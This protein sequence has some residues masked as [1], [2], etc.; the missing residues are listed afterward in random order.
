MSVH[1]NL[2]RVI[3]TTCLFL[4]LLVSVL[5]V[6]VGYNVLVAFN[7]VPPN[8][9]SVGSETQVSANG[10]PRQQVSVI[11]LSSQQRSASSPSDSFQHL[12]DAHVPKHL[13]V[14]WDGSNSNLKSGK[15]GNRD[16]SSS[17]PQNNA[18]SDYRLTAIK[19]QEIFSRNVKDRLL[20]DA[21]SNKE[22]GS[23][24][25]AAGTVLVSQVA[26]IGSGLKKITITTDFDARLVEIRIGNDTI[27]YWPWINIT[28]T[29]TQ[30]GSYWEYSYVFNATSLAEG[31]WSVQARALDASST[32]FYSNLRWFL[33]NDNV[34]MFTLSNPVIIQDSDHVP[35][36]ILSVSYDPLT[37]Y[38]GFNL[39]V[40]VNVIDVGKGVQQV[41]VSYRTTSSV[42]ESP[43][44]N[45]TAYY[46]S[47][48]GLYV[49]FLPS[50]VAGTTVHIKAYAKDASTL[51]NWAVS[52]EITVLIQSP[53][54]NGNQEIP[55]ALIDSLLENASVQYIYFEE[56]LTFWI[57]WG[58]IQGGRIYYLETTN[59]SI[60]LLIGTLENGTFIPDYSQS[61]Q[62]ATLSVTYRGAGNYSFVILANDLNKIVLINVTLNKDGFSPLTYYLL[63]VVVPRP[64]IV[65]V[66]SQSPEFRLGE[67]ATII[68]GWR[69]ALNQS[70]IYHNVSV[71]IYL[72]GTLLNNSQD[73]G[74]LL[75]LL[76]Q[77][78]PLPFQ[79][80][81][82]TLSL[83]PAKFEW[84]RGTYNLTIVLIKNGYEMTVQEFLLEIKGFEITLVVNYPDEV[85]A[86]SDITITVRLQLASSN[87]SSTGMS[88]LL[89]TD[90]STTSSVSSMAFQTLAGVNV[91][92]AVTLVYL[93]GTN[94][95]WVSWD[96][97][98]VL[99][100]VSFTI[101]G[102]LTRGLFAISQIAVSTPG[103]ELLDV[104]SSTIA[105]PPINVL[106]GSDNS[107][108]Q[109]NVPSNELSAPQGPFL[110]DLTELMPL[111]LLLLIPVVGL[112][113]YYLRRSRRRKSVDRQRTLFEQSRRSR[114]RRGTRRRSHGAYGEISGSIQP[115][116]ANVPSA[117]AS[118]SVAD[119]GGVLAAR[120][121]ISDTRTAVS[122]DV[123]VD[124]IALERVQDFLKVAGWFLNAP[125]GTLIAG[126]LAPALNANLSLESVA[127]MHSFDPR[128]TLVEQG[129][130]ETFSMS[131]F[132]FVHV[133]GMQA[134]LVIILSGENSRPSEWL[135]EGM[136]AALNE[137]E[138]HA[139]ETSQALTQMPPLEVVLAL[140]SYLPLQLLYPLLISKEALVRLEHHIPRYIGEG[141]KVILVY[142][143]LLQASH[144]N[145]ND[146]V[147]I[148]INESSETMSRLFYEEIPTSF[149][150]RT[151]LH[152]AWDI[153]TLQLNFPQK[154]AAEII[155]EGLKWEIIRGTL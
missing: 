132:T 146:V 6:S 54:S 154:T 21:T 65:Q 81:N 105:T 127:A 141:L 64:A 91:S 111:I 43:W 114:S 47:T 92:I 83:N 122:S 118:Q 128:A 37:S 48:D 13:Q 33:L 115:N 119:V 82:M 68:F 124:P 137:L 44:E 89:A 101:P 149:V 104:G 138:V 20:V 34:A 41:I 117:S 72:N 55:S 80:W 77:T 2:K 126:S 100:Q 147:S 78:I 14:K 152:A 58:Y 139:A 112:M 15:N 31:Y 39:K 109:D 27:G 121:P 106:P 155:I 50:Q 25:A 57:V 95:T 8:N 10:Q 45:V 67:N 136:I 97:T 70:W 26:D 53:P 46:S 142:H 107:S 3:L 56:N 153:L 24:N 143:Y 103:N 66:V 1:A 123:I 116:V 23:L 150:A 71:Q 87:A 16:Q 131:G 94:Y 140:E 108:P 75:N 29:E 120:S 130:V 74:L 86:G 28:A 59:V 113:L 4:L 96:L 7:V 62:S 17:S 133:T 90:T 42:S 129:H 12:T 63:M 125:D 135:K 36:S 60:D 52:S 144:Q 79:G 18:F 110:P 30:V 22:G 5:P 76:N 69:D 35:P 99:G 61:P 84:V 93:D 98:N 85:T 49:A 51:E 102:S 73:W 40:L 151:N 38:E 88:A 145:A 11:Y 19:S 148:L 134:R 32:Q 9:P